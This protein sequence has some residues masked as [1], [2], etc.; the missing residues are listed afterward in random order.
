MG[1][2]R[3]NSLSHRLRAS[4]LEGAGLMLPA[5]RRD[6]AEDNPGAVNGVY[7]INVI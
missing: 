6:C 3:R 7:I 4:V 1:L 2:T 5:T